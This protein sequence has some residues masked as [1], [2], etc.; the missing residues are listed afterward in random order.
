MTTSPPALLISFSAAPAVPPV[1]SRSSTRTNFPFE[2]SGF[3][4]NESVPCTLIHN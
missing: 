3:I 1:A 4:S 2:R